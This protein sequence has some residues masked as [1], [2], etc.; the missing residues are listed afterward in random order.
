MQAV[1]F[2]QQTDIL[3]KDQP[4]YLPLPVHVKYEQVTVPGPN[5][6]PLINP[7]GTLLTK[8]V[9]MEMTCCFQLS[10][11]EIAQAIATGQ[12]WYTQCVYGNQF[13]PVRMSV[14][15]PF[16]DV[17]V[18]DENWVQKMARLILNVFNH[19]VVGS[20]AEKQ[21]AFN[22]LCEL[23]GGNMIT[24]PENVT[25]LL[26]IELTVLATHSA[27]TDDD[28]MIEAQRQVDKIMQIIQANLVPRSMP[29]SNV[30][31]LSQSF[32]TMEAMEAIT[33]AI[34]A[35]PEYREAWRANIAGAYA[36]AFK[37]ATC[38]NAHTNIS[39]NTLINIANNAA[40][41]FLHLLCSK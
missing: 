23:L 6:L 3:A 26:Q 25:R 7:D 35:D 32:T 27:L 16:E 38:N 39:D 17:T 29:V 34:K 24:L 36:D 14:V 11:E 1:E 28:S 41:N 37:S 15:N 33:G 18:L 13:Q 2:S 19:G 8:P 22:S 21:I 40:D 5:G 10:P 9:P 20:Y 31:K 12:F 30:D 4:Q